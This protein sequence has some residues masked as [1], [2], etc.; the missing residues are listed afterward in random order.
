[1]ESA[2]PRWQYCGRFGPA[3]ICGRGS[4][5]AAAI[6]RALC[7]PHCL[8]VGAIRDNVVVTV[9]YCTHLSRSSFGLFL[10]VSFTLSETRHQRT[11]IIN[12]LDVVAVVISALFA[13][14]LR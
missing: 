12:L 14:S 6:D 10:L 9:S 3:R 11:P 2:P 1:M 7:R 5:A 13:T 4:G 8:P